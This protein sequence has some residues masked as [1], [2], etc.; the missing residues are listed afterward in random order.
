[1]SKAK[2]DNNYKK[3]RGALGEQI[4][5]DYLVRTGYTILERNWRMHPYEIDI[6]AKLK[7]KIIFIEVK[8][9]EHYE[10]IE[11][12]ES[13]SKGQQKRIISAAH[14]YLITKDID[15]ESRF[16]IIGVTE[17]KK[18]HFQVEHHEDAFYPT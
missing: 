7:D 6:I 5:A 8:M 1:M 16:D 17:P 12:W 11:A 3:E 10:L 18:D 9:R 2:K 13:V 15:A 14:E 4:A